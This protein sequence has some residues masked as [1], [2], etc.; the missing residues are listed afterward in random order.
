M[1]LPRGLLRGS[2]VNAQVADHIRAYMPNAGQWLVTFDLHCTQE[3]LVR[4]SRSLFGIGIA[5][6]LSYCSEAAAIAAVTDSAANQFGAHAN[7]AHNTR[8]AHFRCLWPVSAPRTFFR[9]CG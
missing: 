7:I 3:S 8:A 5:R 9:I 1:S 4:G 6:A 2:L